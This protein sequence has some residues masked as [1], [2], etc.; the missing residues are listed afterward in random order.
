MYSYFVEIKLYILVLAF[1]YIYMSAM[2]SLA[3]L[4]IRTGSSKHSLGCL[5]MREHVDPKSRSSLVVV[6]FQ[7]ERR[8]EQMTITAQHSSV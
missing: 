3:R 4:H 1:I 6:V 7:T 5:H 8:I 2:K